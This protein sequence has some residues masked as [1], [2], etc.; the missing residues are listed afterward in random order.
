MKSLTSVLAGGISAALLVGLASPAQAETNLNAT[1]LASGFVT[2]G[3]PYVASVV[4]AT[5]S[6]HPGDARLYAPVLGPFLDLTSRGSCNG[7]D[8]PTCATEVGYKVLL[9]TDG[10]LQTIGTVEVL[11]GLLL[12]P[13]RRFPGDTAHLRFAP[14]RVGRNGYGLGASGVF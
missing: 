7:P 4:V 1:L 10:V 11:T 9:V 13:G 5:R 14:A 6:D 12:P 3:V 2:F 8:E